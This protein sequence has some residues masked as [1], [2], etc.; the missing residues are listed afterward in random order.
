MAATA[1]KFIRLKMSGAAVAF[2]NE[3]TTDAGDHKSYQI[4]N[5]A[6]RVFDPAIAVVVQRSTDGGVSW[7]A[8]VGAYTL[9]RLSGTVTFASA[10]GVSDQIRF[11]SGSY[12]PMTTIAEGKSFSFSAKANY[13]DDTAFGDTEIVRVQTQRM[14]SGA[15]GMW[16]LD[17][18]FLTLFLAGAQLVAE[19][20]MASG[21]TPIVRAWALLTERSHDVAI[22]GL[23]EEPLSFEA[24]QDADGRSYTWLI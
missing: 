22:A 10:N 24:T 19:V 17:S 15:I 1:G 8:A 13:A 23:Q 21:S 6:K 11:A 18:S 7:G 16:W 12:L 3:A 5:P 2:T 9:N 4:T 20:A 14:A